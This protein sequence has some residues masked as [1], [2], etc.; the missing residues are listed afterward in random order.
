MAPLAAIVGV[1]IFTAI[2]TAPVGILAVKQALQSNNTS[3]ARSF[4][5]PP[6][7]VKIPMIAMVSPTNYEVPYWL[8][9]FAVNTPSSSVWTLP[10]TYNNG[11][12]VQPGQFLQIRNYGPAN[13]TIMTTAPETI[14][15]QL[16][17]V[18]GPGTVLKV[19]SN[20]PN[21]VV[22]APFGNVT[23]GAG[24]NCNGTEISL[25]PVGSAGTTAY[26]ASIT[27]N[28]YGQITAKTPGVPPVTFLNN[29]VGV[30]VS[31]NNTINTY[32][33]SVKDYGAVGNGIADDTA[34]LQRAINASL[35]LYF[36]AGT[37]LVSS[38]LFMYASGM[39]WTGQGYYITK[40]V[41]IGSVASGSIPLVANAGA[42]GLTRC[43]FS[44]IGFYGGSSAMD[45]TS[46]TFF[47]NTIQECLFQG[48][49]SNAS[50]YSGFLDFQNSFYSCIFGNSGTGNGIQLLG[51]AGTNFFGGACNLISNPEACCFRILNRAVFIGVN[52]ING[53]PC[54]Y[55][56]EF[57][58]VSPPIYP[59]ITLINCNIEDF[60][61]AGLHFLIDSAVTLKQVT[62]LATVT[63]SY[64]AMIL[65]DRGFGLLLA[66]RGGVEITDCRFGSKGAT[67]NTTL[68]PLDAVI[69]NSA[70]NPPAS[71][72]V[73]TTTTLYNTVFGFT[74]TYTADSYI[75]RGPIQVGGGATAVQFYSKSI[76]YITSN[77][78]W[79]GSLLPNSVVNLA[80]GATGATYSSTSYYFKTANTAPTNFQVISFGT[81][82]NDDQ[83]GALVYIVINDA[84]T[85]MIHDSGTTNSIL[86]SS[87][88]NEAPTLGTV[89]AFVRVKA[90]GLTRWR[91]VGYTTAA[92]RTT[93]KL[94]GAA[95]A[96]SLTLGAG[97]NC[98]STA[99]LTTY[100]GT[101]QWMTLAI[102]TG[103]ATCTAATIATLTF[104]AQTG[105]TT[106]HMCNVMSAN[107]AA[108]SAGFT[109]LGTTTT[110]TLNA[111][112]AGLVPA[113]AYVWYIGPCGGW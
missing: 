52:G 96:P 34:A 63:G 31:S 77:Y 68:N 20:A 27:T 33:P 11:G 105:I 79:S 21:W 72:V 56:G 3:H 83:E 103:A 88:A 5:S 107:A 57:G 40:L 93:T 10:L 94:L 97:A 46:N 48:S 84:F 37:Y 59:D 70:G 71:I 43:V 76:P 80:A 18:I 74:I 16:S 65:S 78:H 32:F 51:G 47:E 12:R 113:T 61:T 109:V 1:L 111:P 95:A 66:S 108:L 102:T 14:D 60:Q 25:T 81:S 82:F 64:T 26:P 104:G 112:A 45:V 54:K 49:G 24:L 22:T 19:L 110:F 42:V 6:I 4:V 17:Y 91:Q 98:G 41:G 69:V 67:L 8:G 38:T 15:F 87:L 86:L 55:W 44:G 39:Y 50:F 35:Q 29:G 58:Q 100:S 28:D 7:P 89:Y 13:I 101:N 99:T 62:F 30:S 9:G 23:C 92:L 53:T 2:L 85:T 75:S 73:Q 36:P 106:S 90:T